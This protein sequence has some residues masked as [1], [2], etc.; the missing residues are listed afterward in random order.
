M[1]FKSTAVKIKKI[2]NDKTVSLKE[3]KTLITRFL[4]MSCQREEIDLKFIVGNYELSIIPKA[5]FASDGLEIPCLNKSKVSM[6][7][8]LSKFNTSA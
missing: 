3:E 8:L 1:T 5:F 6:N 7:I 4:I 2:L